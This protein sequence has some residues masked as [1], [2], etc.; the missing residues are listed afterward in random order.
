M[1]NGTFVPEAS[2]RN[3]VVLYFT[4]FTIVKLSTINLNS[5]CFQS[6]YTWFNY[7]TYKKRKKCKLSWSRNSCWIILL[8]SIAGWCNAYG[9]FR[10]ALLYWKKESTSRCFFPL[11]WSSVN[12]GFQYTLYLLG[13]IN[14]SQILLIRDMNT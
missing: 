7:N 12:A 14:C 10:K 3:E 9:K 8:A 1:N 11:L 13:F 6:H 4:Y 2:S 5:G